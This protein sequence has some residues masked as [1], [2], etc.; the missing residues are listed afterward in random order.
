MPVPLYR[1]TQ[2]SKCPP[3]ELNNLVLDK[4]NATIYIGVELSCCICF[5][6]FFL[7]L[8][9]LTVLC[10][11][12]YMNMRHGNM[13]YKLCCQWGKALNGFY[14]PERGKGW[15]EATPAACRAPAHDMLWAMYLLGAS[16]PAGGEVPACRLQPPSEIHV[17]QAWHGSF[18]TP[19][20]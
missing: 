16:I 15:G 18:G 19:R 4:S 9:F 12:S 13:V 8:V 3:S 17:D 11:R 2:Q 1:V 10:S 20:R 7:Q 6:F 14:A 5:F